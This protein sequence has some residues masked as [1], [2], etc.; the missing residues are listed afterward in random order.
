[1]STFGLPFAV[2]VWP[3]SEEMSPIVNADKMVATSTAALLSPMM[4]LV[5]T[6]VVELGLPSR[7]CK[8]KSFGSMW[9][10]LGL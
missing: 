7:S 6:I 2:S 3:V 9:H 1:M 10:A 4:I 5:S 8:K